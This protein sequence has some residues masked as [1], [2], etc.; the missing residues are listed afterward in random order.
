MT[1]EERAQV[2]AMLEAHAR[3]VAVC[4]ACATTTRDLADEVRR[5]G[6]PARDDLQR[7]VAE[8]ERILVDLAA[9]RLEI[10]RL[11]GHFR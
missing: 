3:T 2:V 1:R 8:A 11:T 4:E 5:G 7:T 9:V 6:T 10:T